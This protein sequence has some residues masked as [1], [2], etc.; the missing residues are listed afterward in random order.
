MSA[1]V[2]SVVAAPRLE[3]ESSMDHYEKAVLQE[4][5]LLAFWPLTHDIT[6]SSGNIPGAVK[7]GQPEFGEGPIGRPSLILTN[8]RYV[9]LGNAPSL[10]TDKSTVEFFFKLLTPPPAGYDPCLIA[11]RSSS[12]DTRFS[13]HVLRDRSALAVWNGQALAIIQPPVP[14]IQIGV[15]HYLAVTSEPGRLDAYLDGVRCIVIGGNASFNLA[16]RDLPLDFGSSSPEGTE[17]AGCALADVAIYR[18]VLDSADIERHIRA[19][20]WTARRN[21][22]VQEMRR[23]Q[24]E[25]SR[26]KRQKVAGW[27]QDKRLMEAGETRTYRGN[28]LTAISIGIGGIGAGTIQMNGKA[29]RSAWQIFNNFEGVTVP[30]SFF[31]IRAQSGADPPIIRALQTASVGPFQA[32]A[33]LSFQGEYPFAR[34]RFEDSALPVN[35]EMEVYNPLIPLDSKSSAIPCAIHRISVTNPTSQPIRVTILGAQ[36]NAVGYSGNGLVFERFFKGYGG[37]RNRIGIEA[38]GSYLYMTAVPTAGDMTLWSTAEGAGGACEWKDLATLLAELNESGSISG[39]AEAGPSPQGETIDG[40]LA[41]SLDVA[42]H[43]TA[44][45]T[46]ILTWYFPNAANG[47]QIAGWEHTGNQYTNWWSSSLEVARYLADNLD[48]LERDTRLYHRTFYESNLPHWLLDRIS[49]QVAILR[50]KTC[51]WSKDGYFGGW[52][53]CAPEAGCCAGNCTHVWH[54]AQAHARLFPDIARRMRQESFGCE[55]KD[56]GVPMRQPDVNPPAFDGQCGE[57]L[58]TYREWIGQTDAQWLDPLWRKVSAAMDYLIRENDPH[59]IGVLSGPQWNTLDGYLGGSTSWMGTLYL[60]ALEACRIMAEHY[61]DDG[62]ARRFAKIRASGAVK[63][64]QT[65]WNGQ[66]YIQLPDAKPYGDYDTGCEIDQVLG[67]WWTH[68]VGLE[69]AYPPERV[70][71]ALLSL[72]RR[73]FQPDFHGIVQRPRQFVAPDDAG[74]QMVTWPNGGRP[75]NCILYADEV[76]TGFEY[77]AAAAMI[78]YGL[79]K[80]GLVVSLAISDRYNGRLRTG[81]TKADWASWGYSGNPFGDDE[82]GKFYARAMS[83]WSLLLACS[84]FIYHALDRRIGF[85]PMWRPNNHRSFFTTAEGWG[86][87]SQRRR[88]GNQ[89]SRIEVRWGRLELSEVRLTLPGPG[90]HPASVVVRLDKEVIQSGYSVTENDALRIELQSPVVIAAGS[91][92]EAVARD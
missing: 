16:Q 4:P 53:G 87:F 57:I 82:C 9:A 78:Q 23:K 14:S 68:Q 29:E 19:A 70:K 30:H 46:F 81:L 3:A 77:A 54:Y 72:F 67:E 34:Y 58:E 40:A 49:S 47:G 65:L 86:L 84:G 26:I 37:N 22:I 91:A 56:G 31:A 85:R 75:S 90:K 89:V 80:E 18:S 59:E 20:G 42:P 15:W 79:L 62:A 76:M 8:G 74:M 60:A 66:Y 7:G 25:Q 88:G 27:L 41:A 21:Q 5:A 52:E 73:N 35:V 64:N 2:V 24:E 39:S 36:Q 10:D 71:T 44:E 17:I 55:E 12:P 51:F 50:S 92:L 69:P 63:Q 13:I 48:D 38:R 28:Y 61:G 83:S 1:A 11:K 33:D 6:D 43:Q 32:M 45:T